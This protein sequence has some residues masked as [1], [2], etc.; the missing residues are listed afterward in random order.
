MVR[1]GHKCQAAA[2]VLVDVILLVVVIL[3]LTGMP[4]GGLTLTYDINIEA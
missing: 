2:T 1:Q 4:N 3:K